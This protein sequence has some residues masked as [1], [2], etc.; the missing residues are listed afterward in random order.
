MTTQ[1]PD[2][3][4]IDSAC[5]LIDDN[6]Q[7]I[8]TWRYERDRPQLV[9]LYEKAAHSQWVGSTDLDWSTDVDP[10][11]LVDLEAPNLRLMREVKMCI[12]DRLTAASTDSAAAP[13]TVPKSIRAQPSDE[14]KC[15]STAATPVMTTNADRPHTSAARGVNIS[16]P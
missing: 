14:V 3:A 10:E 12:R 13:V 11:S 2:R 15:L 4:D 1:L 8:Y 5:K 9:A 16:A 7:S 6:C